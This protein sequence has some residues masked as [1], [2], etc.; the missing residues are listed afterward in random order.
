MAKPLAGLK[1]VEMA[2]IGP[3]PF[4]CMMLADHGADVVRLEKPGGRDTGTSR[5]NKDPLLR[6]RRL[7]EVDLKTP[8]G[9]DQARALI[10][11]ADVVVEGY[12]PGVMERLG[13][14]PEECMADNAA[15]VFARITGWGQEGPLAPRA[16]HDINYIALTGALAA[17]GTQESGPVPPLNLVGDFGGGGMMAAFGIVSAV[18][19]AKLTGRGSVMDAAMLDGTALLMTMPFGLKAQGLW[20]AGRGSNLLDGGAPFYGTYCTADDQWVAIGAIEE[21]FWQIL[22]ERLA[23]DQ[24]VMNHRWD[25]TYWPQIRGLIEDAI[26]AESLAHWE[27]IFEGCDAC[28]APILSMADVTGHPH[29]QERNV[30][31]AP[32][33]VLQPAP[34]PRF[35]GDVPTVPQ[36][37]MT[38]V[39]F[40]EVMKSWH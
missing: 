7:V 27:Q 24:P 18:L 26:G 11:K 33:D 2:S 30:F 19:Q 25:R 34:A 39:D 37:D 5:W 35:D 13:L 40:K 10:A 38:P 16:G 28:F 36:T 12:R 32:G 3:G 6:G 1:V 14:G 9:V 17:T 29:N 21:P 20:P 15:L 8:E 23:L 22:R 4:C 31:Q